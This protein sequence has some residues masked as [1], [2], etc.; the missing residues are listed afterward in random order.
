MLKT[1][2]CVFTF[3]C[4]CSLATATCTTDIVY[5]EC[6]ANPA[7]HH[8]LWQPT[9]VQFERLVFHVPLNCSS[10]S[11]ELDLAARVRTKYVCPR[12][13]YGSLDE[14]GTFTCACP[15][16][17]SCQEPSNTNFALTVVLGIAI[18]GFAFFM[19]YPRRSAAKA[20]PE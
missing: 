11:P 9:V 4:L 10:P 14:D 20:L 3:L 13:E 19:K 2:I 15:V 17:Q 8:A 18:V 6:I 12:G 5:Y 7:C 16:G 1:V